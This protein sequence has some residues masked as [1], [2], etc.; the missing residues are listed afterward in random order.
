MQI[1]ES[2]VLGVRS[3]VW[4]LKVDSQSPQIILF[5]MVH[6]AEESFYNEVIK[7]LEGCD[8]IL[9]EGVKTKTASLLTKSY[10]L[11][12]KNP[13]FDF[14]EQKSMRIDHLKDR[15]VHAD[16]GSAEFEKK[17]ANLPF[18]SRILISLLSPL[19]GVYIRY[20]GTKQFIAEHLGLELHKSRYELLED[21]DS[22]EI[23][24]LFIDWR[25]EHLINV[26][27]SELKKNENSNITIGIVFGAA[28]MRTLLKYLLNQRSYCAVGSEWLTVFKI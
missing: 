1:I 6:I 7:R 4:H 21:D 18:T 17:W 27:N 3:A 9:C 15:I 19:Y 25:D 22:C 20:F 8:L 26:V 5:P 12:T 23:K 10:S 11:I 13:Q 2:T 16:V 24:E 14:V 28:H